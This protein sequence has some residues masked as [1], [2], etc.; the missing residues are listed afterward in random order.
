M[1]DAKGLKYKSVLIKLNKIMHMS[2]GK[3]MKDK[4]WA[5]LFLN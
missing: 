2:Q 5:E 1:S 3:S 4:M